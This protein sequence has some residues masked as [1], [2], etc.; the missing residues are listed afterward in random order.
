MEWLNKI[1]RL[2]RREILRI[3]A[4]DM[5]LKVPTQEI[6]LELSRLADALSNAALDEVFHRLGKKDGRVKEKNLPERFCVLA[7]GKLGGSELNYS[8]DIDLLGLWDDRQK[9][10]EGANHL[11]AF[12]G[13]VMEKFSSDLSAHTEEGYVYRVDLRLRP[14]GR[15]G[16][17]V[18]SLSSL[19]R[20]YQESA[21]LWEIQAALKMRPIAGNMNLGYRFLELI[22]P[23][24]LRKRSRATIVGSIEKMRRTAIKAPPGRQKTGS[25][26]KSGTGGIR[27]VEF[28]VQGLQLIHVP[29]DPSLLHGNTLIALELLREAGI[30]PEKAAWSLKDVYLFL[31]QVEHYLQI[32]E[33][34]Q[35]HAVPT[36]RG[37]LNALSKR[38][39]GIDGNAEAF[40]EK[41]NSCLRE[42]RSAYT[43]FLLE[44]NA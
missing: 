15:E 30:I 31:R 43:T 34:R 21:S 8:S 5:Y 7:M 32:L 19:V 13:K 18:S 37:E 25:D 17:I 42:V 20:Y 36:E 12:F 39:L 24:F 4:R 11:K 2:R 35:V 1:R 3:G 44:E 23:A 33:D 29:E 22:Q 26:V 41:L 28:L 10:T 27:D 16:D 40:A 6:M 38:L 14:F 9:D